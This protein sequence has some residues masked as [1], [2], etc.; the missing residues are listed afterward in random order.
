MTQLKAWL[1]TV[2]HGRQR[3]KTQVNIDGV[4]EAPH[5]NM[6]LECREICELYLTATQ[7]VSVSIF[8]KIKGLWY[9]LFMDINWG[10]GTIMHTMMSLRIFFDFF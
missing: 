5:E 4:G 7:W 1:Q 8:K 6:S 2:G 9:A 10:L 3:H